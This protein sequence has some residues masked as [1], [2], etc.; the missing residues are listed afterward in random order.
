MAK[1]LKFRYIFDP[2][3]D[4][5]KIYG[6]VAQR[7]LL[8]I[9]NVTS[10]RIIYNFSDSG[11]GAASVTYDED[12]DLTNILLRYD[13]TGMNSGD[14]LQIFI[15]D[16]V[17]EFEPS[18][19]FTDPV[20]KFRVSQSETLIDTDFEY[21]LQSTKWET[22]ELVNNIPSFYSK[23]GDTSVVVSTITGVNG[24]SSLSINA[25]SHGLSVGTPV[26]I[27]GL[28]QANLD[29]SYL[30]T[31]V[32]DSDTIVINAKNLSTI[33]GSLLTPYTFVVP[34]RFYSGSQ[35]NYSSIVSD[36][37]D[38]SKITVTT[39]Y[40]SGFK[41]GSEFYLSN[42]VG[43][44]NIS[45]DSSQ[46][47]IENLDINIQ[48]FDPNAGTAFTDS[49]S[50]RVV[51]PWDY[52]GFM[53][54]MYVRA[55][56]FNQVYTNVIGYG[57]TTQIFS[58]GQCV[59]VINGPDSTLPTGLTDRR[60]YFVVSAGSTAFSLAITVGGAATA[61]TAASG[62]GQFAI[63]RG[64]G[65]T[66]INSTTDLFTLS[67][68]RDATAL[69]DSIPLM[70][71][72][73]GV[74]IGA[75]AT[76]G[77]GV[78][79]ST[80]IKERMW[81]GGSITTSF[82]Y[83]GQTL[84]GVSTS[85]LRTAASGGG[86]LVNITDN[87][88]PSSG[89]GPI[90][91]P[92]K[93]NTT[94]NTI[95]ISGHGFEQNDPVTGV[96]QTFK[97][98]SA[99]GSPITGLTSGT[100][101]YLDPVDFNRFGLKSTSIGDRINLTGYSA[102][103]TSHSITATPNNTTANTLY[104]P[105]HGLSGGELVQYEVGTGTSIGGLSDGT[106]YFVVS[107]NDDS[108]NRIKLADSRAGSAL[109]LTTVGV[110]IHT[111]TLSTV[112]A[113]DGAYVVDSL[114]STTQ[115]TLENSA[116]I[117]P[118]IRTF[119][120]SV[121]V[122]LTENTIDLSIH[123]YA[124]GTP[125][126][127]QT[128][129]GTAIGGLTGLTTYYAIRMSKDRIKL[130]ASQSDALAGINTIDLTTVGVGTEHSFT[131]YSLV[132]ETIGIGSVSITSGSKR[133]TGENTSFLSQFKSG[134]P[135]II[136]IGISTIFE[137]TVASVGSNTQ[138][139]IT[140]NSDYTG[141]GLTYLQ[142][143]AL[144]VKSEAYGLHRPFDGGVEINSGY[145]AD[146]QIIRQTRRYFRYQSGKGINSQFAINFNPPVDI[147]TI[148]ASGTTATITT[149]YPHG[150]TT[151]T[152]MQ[153]FIRDVTGTDA[154]VYNGTYSIDSIPSPITLTYTLLS[155]PS[156][157]SADGF[158][159]LV[160]RNWG[161]ALLRAGMFDDQ[162]GLFWEYNGTT[163][164]AV[165][166]NSIQQLS[167]RSSIEKRSNLLVGTNTRYLDQLTEGDKIVIRGQ[168]YK[169]V[170]IS[171]NTTLHVQPAYRGSV[172][173]EGAIVSKTTDDKVQ[174]SDFSIDPC[175]GT[176][177]FGYNIDLTRIQM[178]YIDYSWYGAGKARFGFK[179]TDGEVIYVHQFIHNNKLNEAY[180][181]SGN[182]PARYEIENLGTPSFAPS[183]AH[184]GSTV[185][186]DGTFQNDQ[187]YLFT[188]SSSL[189]TFSGSSETITGNSVGTGATITYNYV[190][191]NGSSQTGI[192]TSTIRTF[193][194][195]DTVGVVIVPSDFVIIPSHGYSPGQL[196]QYSHGGGAVIGGLTN[197]AYYYVGKRDNNSFY[198]YDTEAN[199]ISGGVTGRVNLT[200]GGTGTTHQI[201][202]AFRFTVTT[203]TISGYGERII[204]RLRT[205]DSA[206]DTV[207]T[208]SFGTPITSTFIQSRV[209]VSNPGALLYR[210]SRIGGS[211]SADV[212]FFFVDEPASNT[213]PTYPAL[214]SIGF[215][216]AGTTCGIAHTLGESTPAPSLIPLISI[217][218]APS[219]DSGLTGPLGQKEVL[220]RMQLSLQGVG[221]LTT[222]D[223]EIRLILN[224]QLSNVNW[225]S[226]GA[227][228]LCQLIPHQNNDEITSGVNIYSFRASGGTEVTSGGR[229]SSNTF[230]QDI[231][232]LLSLGN[233]ILGGD[234]TFPDG[235]DVLTLAVVPLNPT[236][237]T[238]SAPF[239]VSGRI[240]WSESQA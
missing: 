124:N 18:A 207:D 93:T 175:D 133:V 127:Y 31:T 119:N 117:D 187:A 158:P 82:Y 42:T 5:V 63:V 131:S 19:T 105:G 183:L 34:G 154:S 142:R 195:S 86:S 70:L 68:V 159:Q 228:S 41:E 11:L 96:A 106:T 144:Y 132:G 102:T 147:E 75:T 200:A 113:T 6:R 30:I 33:T 22:L 85:T 88:L 188:G 236:Q 27:R 8:L 55:G 205:N 66:G 171:S 62:S 60:R 109:D 178:V 163:L 239:S 230:S 231:S 148:V 15:E 101:Y 28:K 214:G 9:T 215:I 189:L 234:G 40:P 180:F 146:T 13:C 201:R 10:G 3:N 17:V 152:G 100:D 122:G 179:G 89:T 150:I 204:H 218:L 110:G 87:N 125:L 130:S 139:A 12:T 59:V 50:T 57:N 47:D 78:G 149:R 54:S 43:T 38:P 108:S 164:K 49:S 73:T 196:I 120:P 56:N 176:G 138:L 23:S 160:I 16:D 61:I 129:G 14:A 115:F 185:A 111:L 112:G 29:G 71:F 107:A 226:Q 229:R 191:A 128:D 7:R 217:R 24:S 203:T 64:F 1:K 81:D 51:D 114:L 151:S 134:D 74:A 211:N 213:Y 91:I 169:V 194:G 223:V 170:H 45:F 137:A 69:T 240:T 238:L 198:F 161:G 79:F 206:W 136:N 172:D 48:T 222:H 80:S 135:L 190:N 83:F 220:N 182:L 202:S 116:Q 235:P 192:T 32:P 145:V 84:S 97:Y 118:T 181:R 94:A 123:R 184:W 26:D 219:V 36:A 167:G 153:V 177:K 165:R 95:Y 216:G 99:T 210:V 92:V 237:I 67:E 232:S 46:I 104:I 25:P 227:P 76:G 156:N 58:T 141:V 77:H 212:D 186:M 221:L 157:T 168:S 65:I 126:L 37:A 174:Q 103:G 35:I 143:S 173:L 98:L 53:T 233:S 197:E 162:N 224:A 2:S 166:R 20:S 209:G 72:N 52:V 208:L 193:N 199:A 90:L 155:T 4:T 39:E 140:E 121:A 44:R 225:T 21:G